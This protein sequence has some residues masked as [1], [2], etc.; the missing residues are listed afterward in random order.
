MIKFLIASHGRSGSTLLAKALDQHPSIR[1]FGEPFNAIE[2]HRQAGFSRTYRD[3]EDPVAFCRAEIYR[4][5]VPDIACIG[6]KLH[7]NQM[8]GSDVEESLWPYL[9]SD[10]AIRI[11]QLRR[12]NLFDSFVSQQRAVR[13]NAWRREPGKPVPVGYADTIEIDVKKCLRVMRNQERQVERAWALFQGHQRL[14]LHYEELAVAFDQ[15]LAS[16]FAFLSVPDIHVDPP[17]AKM[18]T[19]NHRDGISNYEEVRSALEASE[20]AD[21]LR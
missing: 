6:F 4:K 16:V 3:G 8:R 18:N 2:D 5:D 10:T 21:F 12:R 17:L 19:V 15:A 9:Q 14:S 11:I 20:F 7:A 13:A 1:C